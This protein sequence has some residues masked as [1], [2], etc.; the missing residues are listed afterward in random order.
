[1]SESH[2]KPSDNLPDSDEWFEQLVKRSQPQSGIPRRVFL[3]LG[4]ATGLTLGWGCTVADPDIVASGTG[5]E[6]EAGHD[7]TMD[8]SGSGGASSDPDGSTSASGTSGADS[9]GNPTGGSTTATDPT[10]PSTTGTCEDDCECGPPTEETV[11]PAPSAPQVDLNAYVRI[12]TDNT[13][14]LYSLK[15]EMGQGVLTALPMLLAEE[16]EVDWSQ[17]RSEHPIA[18]PRYDDTSLGIDQFTVSSASVA[19]T[20]LPMRQMGAAAREMLIAAAAQQWGVPASECRAELGEVIHDASAQRANYGSLAELAATMPAPQNP[21]LKDPSEYKI[22]GT[23]RVQLGAR[24]KCSG[25]AKYS[26]DIQVPD[27]VVG[28]VAFPPSI[29]GSVASF[30][31]TAA[32]AIAGVRDVVEITAGVAVLADHFWAA[33]QGRNALEVQWNAGPNATLSSTTLSQRLREVVDTGAD[34]L[35]PVLGD[36]EATIQAAGARSLD[37]EYELPYLAHA[38]MEPLNAVA[39]ANGGQIEIW[40][41]TQVPNNCASEVSRVTG[42][43]RQNIIMHVPLLGGGFGRRA[44]NDYVIA[45]VEASVASGLPVKLI[46][47]REDDMKAAQYRPAAFNRMRGAV[48]ESGRPN[49]WIHNISVQGFFGGFFATEGA[50]THFPYAIENRRVTWADPGIGVPCFTWRSVGASHNAFVVESF[51]DELAD[52]AGRDPL[53]VRLEM[54]AASTDPNADRIMTVL[55]DVAAISNWAGGPPAGR[56]HGIAVHQTFGTIVAQVAEVSVEDGRVRVHKVWASVDCG[57][58]VNPK[59]I[60]AQVEGSIMFALSAT[61]YGRITIENGAAMETNFNTYPLVRISEAPDV[62]VSIVNSGAAIT[63]MGEPAVPPLPAAVCNAVF[64]A[65]GQRVRSLPITLA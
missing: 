43:S 21:P 18:D 17:I 52:L 3:K 48:D 12:G 31:A 51:I 50:S 39:F 38:P 49:A 64:Q 57:Y 55:E 53:E 26:I 6:D 2:P 15:C 60:E 23:P 54:L 44:A 9:Q 10:D 33:I 63:G 11:D 13:I 37:V 5:G 34:R 59:G 16:L 58:A 1:M 65:T 14:T 19:T 27:M 35:T 62:E 47:T 20:Y 4:G 41:G 32:R 42:V 30:D 22:V 40:A 29:G 61:L 45:A 28:V 46:Y 25:Q 7:S 36:P 8:A 24:E 56:G